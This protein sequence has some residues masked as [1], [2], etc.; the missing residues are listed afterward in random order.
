M[1]RAGVTLWNQNVLL[2]GVNANS[3]V[4]EELYQGLYETGVAPFYLHHADWTP[5]TFGFRVSIEQG[6]SIVREL[7]G[8][9]P[10]PAIPDYVLDLPGGLGKVPLLDTERVRAPTEA[11]E[12]ALWQL[13]PTEKRAYGAET[14]SARVYQ[15]VPPE[16]RQGPGIRPV[17]YLD[18]WPN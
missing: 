17:T 2:R 18:L 8:R 12:A 16:T 3:Q 6:R 14:G 9:L 15:I 13:E 5:G 1:A 4:L 7:K 10:G 11:L